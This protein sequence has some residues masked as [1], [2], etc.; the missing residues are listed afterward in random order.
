MSQNG[1]VNV[2]ERFS[3][4]A[5]ERRPRFIFFPTVCCLLDESRDNKKAINEQTDLQRWKVPNR[6]WECCFVDLTWESR[7]DLRTKQALKRS[8]ALTK[9]CCAV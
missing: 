1:F 6:V 7:D 4:F 3:R 8:Y 2:V 5:I 9:A